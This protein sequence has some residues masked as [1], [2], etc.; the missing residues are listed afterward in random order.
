MLAGLFVLRI[1]LGIW[2][3]MSYTIFSIVLFIS[4]KNN[5]GILMGIILNLQMV[6]GN[7]DIL[8]ILI[9]SFYFFQSMNT[10]NFSICLSSLIY[11]IKIYQFQLYK[12]FASWIKFILKYFVCS[13]YIVNGKFSSYSSILLLVY[14]NATNFCMLI[15]F[16]DTLLN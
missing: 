16:P 8:A 2:V 4:V 14:K 6:L 5:I 3:F 7:V 1:T 11:S 12:S 13:D 9:F 15:F 10:G